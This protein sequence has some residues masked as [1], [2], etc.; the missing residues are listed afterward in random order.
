MCFLDFPESLLTFRYYI[1]YV[2]LDFLESLLIFNNYNLRAFGLFR[3]S[4]NINI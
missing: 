2:F 1:S 4:I 3:K